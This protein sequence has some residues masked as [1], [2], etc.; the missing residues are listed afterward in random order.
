[1][2]VKKKTDQAGSPKPRRKSPPKPYPS[3]PLEKALQVAIKIKDLNGG[4]PWT[5]EDIATALGMGSK[6]SDFYYVTAAARDFGLTVGT[7]DTASIELT[8]F[9]RDLVYAPK[10]TLIKCLNFAP[11][12]TWE[13]R[14]G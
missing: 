8:D 2:A 13:P 14:V 3:V 1:M 9:G 4:N 10:E 6:S 12:R 5:P 7:R 11:L